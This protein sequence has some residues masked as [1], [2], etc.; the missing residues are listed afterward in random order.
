MRLQNITH[1]LIGVLYSPENKKAMIYK[2]E[3]E[4]CMFHLDQCLTILITIIISAT[5]AIRVCNMVLEMLLRLILVAPNKNVFY[6]V[7]KIKPIIGP[8]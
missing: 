1:F 8:S 7:T 5:R 2:R 6:K 4:L 3:Q